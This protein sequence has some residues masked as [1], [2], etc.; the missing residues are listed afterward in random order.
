MYKGI[1]SQL[2]DIKYK[3]TQA[4]FQVEFDSP[5]SPPEIQTSRRQVSKVVLLYGDDNLTPLVMLLQ[6]SLKLLLETVVIRSDK[7]LG[8][9]SP[10]LV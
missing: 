3:R 4:L 8:K 5:P 9:V 6:N 2:F 7:P 10:Q 1:D